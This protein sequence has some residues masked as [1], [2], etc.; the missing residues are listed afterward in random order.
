[1]RSWPAS[2][3]LS[4]LAIL[5]F[6]VLRRFFG[7]EKV[8][9]FSVGGCVSLHRQTTHTQRRGEGK[10][11]ETLLSSFSLDA[12]MAKC[13]LIW[14]FQAKCP[15]SFFGVERSVSFPWLVCHLAEGEWIKGPPS[16]SPPWLL[17][18]PIPLLIS[19][20]LPGRL[21]CSALQCCGGICGC[22]QWRQ[23]QSSSAL[24]AS[25][26]TRAGKRWPRQGDEEPY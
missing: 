23:W 12:S 7:G 25:I 20:F 11:G 19:D 13:I 9:L 15:L 22:R 5:C 2:P 10:R 3:L 26:P 1:M 17:P 24:P 18:P 8:R 21:L 6:C 14:C 16:L 4:S